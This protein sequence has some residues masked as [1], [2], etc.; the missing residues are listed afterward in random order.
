M[1]VYHAAPMILSEGSVIQPG[2]WGRMLSMYNEANHVFFREYVLEE[3]R[4]SLFPTKPSRLDALFAVPTL[5]GAWAY[6]QANCPFNLIYEL[7]VDVE[8]HQIHVGSYSMQLPPGPDL[9][10]RVKNL[11]LNYWAIAPTSE[12]ELVIPYAGR[13][14]RVIG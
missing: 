12:V 10:S 1:I 6:R 11:A 9:A 5:E 7:D 8:E 13:V 14:M 2:N 4:A 3:T